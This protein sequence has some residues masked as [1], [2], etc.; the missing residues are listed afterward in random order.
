MRIPGGKGPCL[1]TEEGTVLRQ[2]GFDNA[3]RP[4]END[5]PVSYLADQDGI[6]SHGCGDKGGTVPGNVSGTSGTGTARNSTPHNIIGYRFTPAAAHAPGKISPELGP[7]NVPGKIVH[8]NPVERDQLFHRSF[9]RERSAGPALVMA[10]IP[11]AVCHCNGD[12]GFGTGRPAPEREC[13]LAGLTGVPV[14][15]SRPACTECPAKAGIAGTEE[16]FRFWHASLRI[17]PC[18]T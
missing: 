9:S 7:Y 13:V 12:A 17:S 16:L 6:S 5:I 11:M 4:D 1:S 14:G 15:G 2:G 3:S 8:I 10:G 18:L